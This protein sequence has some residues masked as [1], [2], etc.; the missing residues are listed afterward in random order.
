MSHTR[1]YAG[2]VAAPARRT[3]Y[4]WNLKGAAAVGGRPGGGAMGMTAFMDDQRSQ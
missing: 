3:E 1:Y 4:R 2:M